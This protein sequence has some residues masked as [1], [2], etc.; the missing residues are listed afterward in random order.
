MGLCFHM[1]NGHPRTKQA[2]LE[3]TECFIEKSRA[4]VLANHL[5]PNAKEL[6]I[7]QIPWKFFVGDHKQAR[8]L[9]NLLQFDS[10]VVL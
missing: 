10:L 2:S 3:S 8:T 5:S 6:P 9:D 7:L 4:Q 1:V